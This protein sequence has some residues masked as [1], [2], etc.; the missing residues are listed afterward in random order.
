MSLYH[1]SPSNDWPSTIPVNFV[2]AGYQHT[3]KGFRVLVATPQVKESEEFTRPGELMMVW[4][5]QLTL[6]TGAEC[7]FEGCNV[8]QQLEQ[9]AVA[10]KLLRPQLDGTLGLN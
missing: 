9:H 7:P 4:H 5:K 3:V 6:C 1:I 2:S 10:P 8:R